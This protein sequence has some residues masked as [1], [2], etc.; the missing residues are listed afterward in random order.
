MAEVIWQKRAE[1][2]FYRYLVIGFKEFGEKAANKFAERV[3]HINVELSKYPEIG[4]PEPLLKNRKNLYRAFQ[5]NR[6]FKLIDFSNVYSFKF[7]CRLYYS[8]N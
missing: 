4:Y 6:R 3:G 2:E 8:L 1:R 5:I 7:L